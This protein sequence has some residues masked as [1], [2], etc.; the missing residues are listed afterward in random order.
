MK[1]IFLLLIISFAPVLRVEANLLELLKTKTL[2]VVIPNEEDKIYSNLMDAIDDN[3]KYGPYK[4]MNSKDA[5]ELYTN[6]DYVFLHVLIQLASSITGTG[7]L[8]L[9]LTKGKWNSGKDINKMEPLRVYMMVSNGA[10]IHCD[11]NNIPA[12]ATQKMYFFCSDFINSFKY[13]L[14]QKY[15]T[16]G[17]VKYCCNKEEMAAIKDTISKKTVLLLDK[18][19]VLGDAERA[20][21]LR[22]N[23]NHPNLNI[24]IVD[25]DDI[26]MA[27][28]KRESNT[29]ISTNSR[30]FSCNKFDALC[31]TPVYSAAE[32]KQQKQFLTKVVVFASASVVAIISLVYVGASGK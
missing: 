22:E 19:D 10:L 18:N 11:L 20:A 29:M 27:L 8:Q 31:Y 2:I 13:E 9:T 6:S 4:F 16:D 24:L 15:P 23:L 26:E 12:I 3:W 1:K 28:R 32:K 14:Q 25:Y 5:K 17:L 21:V 7:E 30:I